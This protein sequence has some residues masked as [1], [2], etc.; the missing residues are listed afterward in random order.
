[1]TIKES[2]LVGKTLSKRNLQAWMVS[3]VN[4]AKRIKEEIHELHMMSSR[5]RRRGQQL[6]PPAMRSRVP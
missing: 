5:K 2:E 4:S 6:P 3:L 1:M